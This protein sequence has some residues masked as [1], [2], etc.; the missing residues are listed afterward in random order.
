MLM[1]ASA[2]IVETSDYGPRTTISMS[3][4]NVLSRKP[5]VVEMRAK[6]SSHGPQILTYC[7]KRGHCLSQKF[8]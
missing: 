4:K 6:S 5:V 8:C 7:I 1:L 3:G 2:R